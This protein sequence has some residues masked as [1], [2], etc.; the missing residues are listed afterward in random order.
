MLFFS[1]A[2]SKESNFSGRHQKEERKSYIQDISFRRA[3]TLFRDKRPF[4]WDVEVN[5][6]STQ[7]CHRLGFSLWGRAEKKEEELWTLMR[8]RDNICCCCRDLKKRSFV[9]VAIIISRLIVYVH[10]VTSCYFFLYHPVIIYHGDLSLTSVPSPCFVWYLE[11]RHRH[12]LSGVVRVFELYLLIKGA[13][14]RHRQA[15][16]PPP[17]LTPQ[18]I[19]DL[20]IYGGFHG[21]ES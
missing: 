2:K 11:E 20:F 19:L 10:C 7:T 15:M 12:T 14:C 13:L 3:L 17:L 21:I 5:F 4:W 9:E 16:F 6:F 8:E 1:S 18:K